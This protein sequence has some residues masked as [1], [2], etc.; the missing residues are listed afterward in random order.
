MCTSVFEEA[1]GRGQGLRGFDGWRDDGDRMNGAPQ[2]QLAVTSM[3]EMCG[4]PRNRERGIS[5]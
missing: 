1:G 5:G 4:H 3:L 2:T